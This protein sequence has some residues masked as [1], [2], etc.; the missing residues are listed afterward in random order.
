MSRR[1]DYD[2][3]KHGTSRTFTGVCATARMEGCVDGQRG[4]PG[5]GPFARVRKYHGLARQV[6]IDAY[7]E[8]ARSGP[9]STQQI[10]LF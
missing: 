10:G 6:Y 1:A 3:T 4:A 7:R 8:Y 9:D 2:P 5:S